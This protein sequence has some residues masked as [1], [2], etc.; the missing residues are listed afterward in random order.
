MLEPIRTNKVEH[1]RRIEL[2]VSL[3]ICND[4]SNIGERGNLLRMP[5]ATV[6]SCVITHPTITHSRYY[7]GTAIPLANKKETAIR[8]PTLSIIK[9]W[10]SDGPI[11]G[12]FS[13]WNTSSGTP[14]RFIAN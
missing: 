3:E 6:V 7:P 11:V 2:M 13:V 8:M 1:V 4:M 5:Y 12:R 9:H 14:L 10:R